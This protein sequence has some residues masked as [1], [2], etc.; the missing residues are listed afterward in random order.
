MNPPLMTAPPAAAYSETTRSCG[1]ME[2]TLKPKIRKDIGT[3]ALFIQV[4][5]R[6]KHADQPRSRAAGKGLLAPHIA[7][8]EADLC[9]ECTRTLL[10]G[11]AKRIQ[12]P[13]A[14]KPPCKRCPA[15][16]YAPGHREKVRAIMKYSGMRL[17]LGG[18]LDLLYHYWF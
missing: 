13:M 18:R 14:P 8:L 5:C 11:A 4:Y 16:C 12:C 15:P 6:A 7:P 10:H 17:M 3:L 1:A 9:A 2:S